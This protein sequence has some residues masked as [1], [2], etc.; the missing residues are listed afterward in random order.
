M[1]LSSTSSKTLMFGQI[2]NSWS[3]GDEFAAGK[4]KKQ[5]PTSEESNGRD[6]TESR[7]PREASS[8]QTR[9]AMETWTLCTIPWP[10]RAR[11]SMLPWDLLLSPLVG[12]WRAV[13]TLPCCGRPEADGTEMTLDLGT[14]F[15]CLRKKCVRWKLN[16]FN[17]T[18][19][20]HDVTFFL[21]NYAAL[22]DSTS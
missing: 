13:R 3:A 11:K 18:H 2:Q 4:R 19:W 7:W 1:H 14:R 16:L 15:G 10:L 12:N 8:T 5:I 6:E 17:L 20:E 21:R 22:I 9:Q